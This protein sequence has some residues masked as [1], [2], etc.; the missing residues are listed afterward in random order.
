MPIF[1]IT[2][3][4]A[5]QIVNAAQANQITEIALRVAAIRQADASIQY[6]MGFDEIND[7]DV[8]L[9]TEGIDVVFEPVYKELLTGAILDFVELEPGDFRFIFL[10][11]N[12]PH[13]VPPR[14][15]V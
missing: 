2:P 14:E 13:F 3:R 15:D 8:H 6:Q 1:E 5:T 10:N 7:T 11:P 9:H 4:A 12:D